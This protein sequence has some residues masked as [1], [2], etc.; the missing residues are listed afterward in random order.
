MHSN[1][2]MR[3]GDII[4]E[5]IDAYKLFSGKERTNRIYEL[6][7]RVGL[8]PGMPNASLMNS[9]GLKTTNWHSACF[10]SRT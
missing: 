5:G 10:G 2:R 6:L 9:I 1:P 4:A 8:S 7:E 3:V